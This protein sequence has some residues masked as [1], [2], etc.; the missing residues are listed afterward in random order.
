MGNEK[1][2]KKILVNYEMNDVC[3]ISGG[4][5]SQEYWVDWDYNTNFYSKLYTGV[6]IFKIENSNLTSFKE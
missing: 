4:G 3:S 2:K 5:Y 6:G 1:G